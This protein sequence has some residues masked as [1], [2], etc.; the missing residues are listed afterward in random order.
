[1]RWTSARLLLLPFPDTVLPPSGN[2]VSYGDQEFLSVCTEENRKLELVPFSGRPKR[3][4]PLKLLIS[5]KSKAFVPSPRLLLDQI[6][7]GTLSRLY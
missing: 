1:M 4:A 5:R 7:A 6:L 3:S 2:D